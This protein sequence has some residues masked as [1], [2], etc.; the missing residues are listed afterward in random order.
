MNSYVQRVN[1][2][3]LYCNVGIGFVLLLISESIIGDM[4]TRE[5]LHKGRLGWVVTLYFRLVYVFFWVQLKVPRKSKGVCSL[6]GPVWHNRSWMQGVNNVPLAPCHMLSPNSN[7]SLHRNRW[8][9][10][11]T[12]ERCWIAV[13]SQSRVK[14]ATRV[15]RASFGFLHL[16][17]WCV[18]S[19]SRCPTW[20]GPTSDK[21]AW[22][23]RSSTSWNGSICFGSSSLGSD[24][25]GPGF[26]TDRESSV[27]EFYKVLKL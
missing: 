9:L 17:I 23:F 12:Q 18:L 7:R 27:S 14:T 3:F 1:G 25:C 5:K 6:V 16:R 20:G 2:L 26:C 19:G 8:C 13:K 15:L 24:S 11:G 21:D 10:K 22:S 4:V